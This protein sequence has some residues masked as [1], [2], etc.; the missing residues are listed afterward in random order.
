MIYAAIWN[1]PLN[2]SGSLLGECVRIR[3]WRK[4]RRFCLLSASIECLFALFCNVTWW[5]RSYSGE[6]L[7]YIHACCRYTNNQHTNQLQ[8]KRIHKCASNTAQFMIKASEYLVHSFLSV[9]YSWKRHENSRQTRLAFIKV[10]YCFARICV[11]YRCHIWLQNDFCENL[12]A[13]NFIAI[14]LGKNEQ[15]KSLR[16]S[17]Q[18]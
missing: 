14:T 17:K 8:R 10:W 1:A 13:A 7:I 5:Y 9:L 2:N 18:K 15:C 4:K 3:L 6:K 12:N 16:C 11:C